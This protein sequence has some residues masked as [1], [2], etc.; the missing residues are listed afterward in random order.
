MAVSSGDGAAWASSRARGGPGGDALG[1]GDG[2]DGGDA[3]SMG[4]AAGLAV[5]PAR[6]DLGSGSAHG[7]NGGI[8]RGVGHRGGIL[9]F[10]CFY[11]GWIRR[12]HAQER[13]EQGGGPR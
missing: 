12:E 5:G 2:G 3:F 1:I 11:P 7:G 10:L 6:V 4:E 8:G 9:G 13:G